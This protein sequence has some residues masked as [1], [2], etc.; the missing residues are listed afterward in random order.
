[1][2][3]LSNYIMKKNIAINAKPKKKS[4]P[5]NINSNPT[6]GKFLISNPINQVASSYLSMGQRIQ[7]SKN[8]KNSKIIHVN[9]NSATNYYTVNSKDSKQASNSI[10]NSMLNNYQSNNISE[11]NGINFN[12]YLNNNLSQQ[13]Y[14]TN[15]IDKNKNIIKYNN[16]NINSKGRKH[17]STISNSL[18]PN[19]LLINGYQTAKNN[20]SNNLINNKSKTKITT[21]NS[22]SN[23]SKIRQT[24]STRPNFL[25]SRNK[26]KKVPMKSK[27][28]QF[29][30]QYKGGKPVSTSFSNVHIIKNNYQGSVPRN[31]YNYVRGD[32][33]NNITNENNNDIFTKNN[34]NGNYAINNNNNL[35]EIKGKHFR[36]N[37]ASF[38]N[39]DIISIFNKNNIID[40]ANKNINNLNLKNVNNIGIKSNN[41]N[42]CI[43][44]INNI[45]N[46]DANNKN[47]NINQNRNYLSKNNNLIIDSNINK[48]KN[49]QYSKG[50][51][52]DIKDIKIYVNEKKINQKESK[53]SQILN[54]NNN[55]S[56]H[57]Y[58]NSNTNNANNNI[59]KNYHSNI[60]NNNL[61]KDNYNTNNIIHHM[62]NSRSINMNIPGI[63]K[64]CVKQKEPKKSNIIQNKNNDNNNN[65]KF[66]NKPIPT[67][68]QKLKGGILP[69]QRNIKINLAKF[70]DDVKNKQNN[71]LVMGRKS[72]SIKRIT[73]ENNS[74]FS[75]S[76]LNDKFTQKI[77]KNNDEG[78]DIGNYNI[79]TKQN[80][81]KTIQEDNIRIKKL[82][83]E[84]E[85]EKY[86]DI[87]NNI[88][89]DTNYISNI[90]KANKNRLSSMPTNIINEISNNNANIYNNLNYNKLNYNENASTTTNN[91][92]YGKNKSDY[93]V[94][95]IPDLTNNNLNNK[96]FL[97]NKENINEL[98]INNVTDVNKQKNKNEININSQN[99]NNKNNRKQNNS[100]TNNTN[101]NNS[102]DISS[103]DN[104]N[105]NKKNN[106]SVDT[107]ISKN[108]DMKYDN[109]NNKK[110]DINV[111]ISNNLFDDDNLDE[112]PKDY[113]ENFNDLYSIINKMNFGNV[114]VCVEG[115]F[116]PEGR[117]YK[118]Y[119]DKFD[120]FYDKL[121][122]KKG[123]SF[124][125]S[126]IKPK[127]IMEGIS[128]TSNTKTNSSSSKKNIINPMYNDLNIVKDL[129]AY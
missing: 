120:K 3:S 123:N 116:T 28:R 106:I 117:T 97:K 72:L 75:L 20:N 40:K 11:N 42:I 34:T 77:L 36:H 9:T 81:N 53:Y 87:D 44:N 54:N 4:I 49:N 37:T 93:S 62:K 25:D 10:A 89:I 19:D 99:I 88:L 43:N 127:K 108:N 51:I 57:A 78:N 47:L 38:D 95:N 107:N 111:N 115:L 70:L 129:N 125:N 83:E 39:K 63:K 26:T 12:F 35:Y 112:L 15:S 17:L 90:N 91:N 94:D 101:D 100:N 79:N 76:Q 56:N 85:N 65:A 22:K 64:I 55:I 8:L 24:Y 31:I 98:N 103:I 5:I 74:D 41:S 21:T 59:Y 2:T 52:N 82:E 14:E 13:H 113:D 121:Y 45:N 105:N 66:S 84:K 46:I 33:I 104:N 110:I 109:I 122:T 67:P 126:N 68:S 128:M 1:M 124:A 92:Y 60:N 18:L 50:K 23:I 6:P 27:L 7:I 73:K 29:K 102:H 114:L 61:I 71:K 86:N 32:L 48:R 96:G 119:K 118:K 16:L 69:S 58:Y 80:I 30:Y